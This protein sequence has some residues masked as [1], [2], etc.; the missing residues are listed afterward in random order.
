MNLAALCGGLLFVLGIAGA[1]FWEYGSGHPLAIYRATS[2]T[3]GAASHFEVQLTP[4]MNPVRVV[5]TGSDRRT[6]R[7]R[8]TGDY[9]VQISLNGTP[10]LRNSAH[11]R[12]KSSG[13]TALRTAAAK[14]SSL[15][16]FNVPA[17]GRYAVDLTLPSEGGALTTAAA[18]KF[19]RNASSPP[20]WMIRASFVAGALGLLSLIASGLLRSRRTPPR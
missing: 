2:L 19:R 3:A 5:F 6:A 1:V 10:V 17:P 11:L 7:V 13:S 4:D 9:T 20:P 8:Q 16:T 15:G 18:V 14:S 12:F